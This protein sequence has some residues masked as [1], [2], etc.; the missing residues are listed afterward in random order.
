MGSEVPAQGAAPYPGAAARIE[1]LA[2]LN[3][4]WNGHGAMRVAEA[5]RKAALGFLDRVR[6]EFGT[7]VPEPTVVAPTSD[8]GIALEWIVRERTHE[9]GVEVVFLPTGIEYS[10]RNRDNGR[11]EDDRENVDVDFLLLNVIKPHVAGHFVL[12]K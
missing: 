8:G 11:L 12:A 6:Q 3:R 9:K 4:D 10:L 1:Q 7:S 2:S 5:S